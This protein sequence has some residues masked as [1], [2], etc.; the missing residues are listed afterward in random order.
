MHVY[1]ANSNQASCNIG[2]TATTCNLLHSDN[3]RVALHCLRVL[4]DVVVD[5]AHVAE[6]PGHVRVFRPQH[7]TALRDGERAVMEVQCL[8]EIAHFVV[9]D[10]TT[11]QSA[12]SMW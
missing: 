11:A 5:V 12:G 1:V 4:A 10:A 3:P 9:R 8:A 6:G 2:V 7:A